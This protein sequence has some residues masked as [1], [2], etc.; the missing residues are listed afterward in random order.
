MAQDPRPGDRVGAWL[1]P[2]LAGHLDRARLRTL[3]DLVEH[4][5]GI[6]GRWWAQVPGVGGRKAARIL[7]WL[8]THERALG[9]RIGVRAA[10]R[11][12]DLTFDSL[13]EV[14]PAAT[15]L[16]PLEK[17]VVP[18]QLD[19]LAGRFRAPPDRCL[20]VAKDDYAAIGAWLTS[21]GRGGKTV[22]SPL[23]S[24]PNVGKRRG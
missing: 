17:F 5:N 10:R 16:R 9:L 19:G 13:T 15:A 22:S 11:R 2:R 3:F 18:A 7:E 12:S 6:G 24:G 21:K 1:N 4:M 8:Q 20:L 14:M 23:R